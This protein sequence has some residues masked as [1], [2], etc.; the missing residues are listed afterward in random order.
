M[1]RRQRVDRRPDDSLRDLQE[2]QDHQYD[3]GYLTG[4]RVRPLQQ[5]RK[6]MPIIGAIFISTSILCGLMTLIGSVMALSHHENALGFVV[7]GGCFTVVQLLM[8]L[9]FRRPRRHQHPHIVI[10]NA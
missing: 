1:A 4:S 6:P 9:R 10:H 3:P 5:I 7:I 8:G 2:W